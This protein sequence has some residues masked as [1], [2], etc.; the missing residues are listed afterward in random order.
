[1]K[2]VNAR[3]NSTSELAP[4]VLYDLTGNGRPDLVRTTWRGMPVILISDDGRFPWPRE[5]ENRDWDGFLS[6]AF[7]LG[8]GRPRTWNEARAGWGS[9]TILVDKDAD[10]TFDGPGD[11][12]YKAID[13]DGDGRPEAE[14]IV[15]PG[16][17][18]G[19]LRL[20]KLFICLNGSHVMDYLDWEQFTYADEQLYTGTGNYIHGV[21]GNGLFLNGRFGPQWGGD[22]RLSW[23]N[24]IAFY[25]FDDDG[26]TDLVIRAADAPVPWH[27]WQDPDRPVDGRLEEFE[28]AFDLDRAGGPETPSHLDMQITFTAYERGG[29]PYKGY[30]QEVPGL[31][32]LP[33]AD[34]LFAATPQMRHETRRCFLPYFDG[35]KIGTE[36]DDWEAVWLLFDEDND[37]NRWEEMFSPYEDDWH[38][39]ADHIGDRVEHDRANRGK[40]RLYV[41]PFDGKIHL[42]GAEDG[43]WRVDYY[44]LYK[45]AVD[46]KDTAEG[47]MPPE[48]LRYPLIRY[49]DTDGDGFFDRIEYLTAEFGREETTAKVQRVVSLGELADGEPFPD[50][51]P[52]VEIR[53]D[54]PLTGQK[55]EDWDG[56]PVRNIRTAARTAYERLCELFR[57]TTEESWS[58]ARA[59]Y[60][61]ARRRGWNTSRDDPEFSPLPDCRWLAP[62]RPMLT[63]QQLAGLDEIMVLGGYSRLLAPQTLM[64]KY[65]NA[66]WLKEKVFADV[67][68]AAPPA[69]HIELQRLYYFGRFDELVECIAGL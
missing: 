62:E 4:E 40:G 2:V 63:K 25:D 57:R 33:E 19:I 11:F 67:L 15:P 53:V 54:E 39:F 64:Q 29:L 43:E 66:F 13:V 3:P 59:L 65:R 50:G 55:L 22:I 34:F 9:Y 45:G 18:G 12:Y 16:V 41:A 56:K 38:V 47:P 42:Y 24:P 32:G 48:G 28:V 69:A 60:E 46:R 44:G 31:G 58:R 17:G 27:K 36:Y 20:E 51:L 49:A 14:F 1:M 37:D 35:Y 8:E 68:S 26:C 52:I 10:G 6:D 30:E 61:A 23:E 5:G 21:H 7:D